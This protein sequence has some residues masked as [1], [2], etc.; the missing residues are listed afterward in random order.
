MC[1]SKEEVQII[2][3]AIKNVGGVNEMSLNNQLIR[4]GEKVKMRIENIELLTRVMTE[5]AKVE[6]LTRYMDKCCLIMNLEYKAWDLLHEYETFEEFLNN[7][8]AEVN[9][10]DET[11]ED[12]IKDSIDGL[13]GIFKSYGILEIEEQISRIKESKM[14]LKRDLENIREKAIGM[15]ITEL[16][17]EGIE[18]LVVDNMSRNEG[19]SSYV[20]AI[21]DEEE[22]KEII[23][24]DI[25][26]VELY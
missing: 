18:V 20:T 22:M 4:N 21:F 25:F 6:I 13:R 14:E 7:V 5:A 12:A 19:N 11:M 15:A 23:W 10:I 24:E 3:V 1:N 9:R 2:T 17:N 26:R 16:E 8:A